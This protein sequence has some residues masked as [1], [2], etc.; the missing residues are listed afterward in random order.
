MLYPSFIIF[1]SFFR[2]LTSEEKK[3]TSEIISFLAPLKC[4]AC[5]FPSHSNQFVRHSSGKSSSIKSKA[6]RTSLYAFGVLTFAVLVHPL[7]FL[8]FPVVS[9][10]FGSEERVGPLPEGEGR[11][12]YISSSLLGKKNVDPEDSD[13]RLSRSLS[14]PGSGGRYINLDARSKRVIARKRILTRSA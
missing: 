10:W 5:T 2:C 13:L 9:V 8:N 6:W 4:Q 7:F 12:S 11:Y 3:R 1:V 14:H